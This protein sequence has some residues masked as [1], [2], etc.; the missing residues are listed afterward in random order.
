MKLKVL[1][2]LFIL[3]FPA[4]LFGQDNS[5]VYRQ[6]FSESFHIR[7][8]RHLELKRY[9]DNMIEASK[10]K[11]LEYFQPDFTNVEFYEES[12]KPYREEFLQ[13]IGYPPPGIKSSSVPKFDY[14]AEDSNC[15][16]YR[17]LLEVMEG[18]NVHG[19]YLVPR[20][21]KG[22]APLLICQHGGS[23][24]PEAICDLD[25]REPYHEMGREAVKRGYIVWAPGLAMQCSYGG[26]TKI[27][28]AYRDLLARKAK[29]IGTSLI[30]IEMHKIIRSTEAIIQYRKN[31]IDSDRIGMT[32]LSYGG[33]FTIFTSVACPLIKVGAPSGWF[34]DLAGFLKRSAEQT[35]K[36][37]DR[38]FFNIINKYGLAQIVG[39]ICPRPLQVQMGVVDPVFDIVDARKEV[40]KAELY[41]IKLGVE[42]NFIYAE[43]A[44]GHEF[45]VETIL[46]FFDKYLK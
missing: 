41:Y 34:V 11:C 17:V 16:I 44:G 20:N 33:F 27:E 25:T 19:L 23:G 8:E 26:D 37:H 42:K 21:L 15:K 40:K 22:K 36:A 2:L 13:M 39:M 30:A 24:C 5:D 18:V 4:N 28:G 3:V 45:D 32:G 38:Q 9:L 1:L 43:H 7:K 6:K 35:E 14:I 12:L 46:S 29:L 10:E 31:E